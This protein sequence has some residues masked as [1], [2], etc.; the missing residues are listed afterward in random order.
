MKVVT[1][2]GARPQFIKCAPVSREL[3]KMATE[4]LVHTGQH[5][6][7]T[8]S[9]VFFRELE[10]PR[11]DYNLGVGSGPHGVQ[12]GETLKRIEEVLLEERP[13]HVVVYGD[14][15]S[16]LAGALAAAKLHIPVAHVEA[17][18]RS[19]NKR[20]PEEINR[21]MTDHISTLLFCPTETAVTNLTQEGMT[22][23]VHLVGD[24]MYD[25]LHSNL[26]LAE[27]MSTILEKL[28]LRSKGYLLTTVHRAENTDQPEN[29]S[30]IVNALIEIAES[31]QTVVFP[32]HPRTRKQLDALAGNG[33]AGLLMIDPVSYLDMVVLE[34]NA[35]AVLTDSGGV[36]KEVCW[37]GVPCVTLRDET[38]WV[39]TL[40]DGRNRLAGADTKRIY[41]AVCAALAAPEFAPP[42]VHPVGAANAIITCLANG[43]G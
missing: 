3:R 26:L 22:Q 42:V 34:K 7:D 5:Y 23:G 31:G 14:T 36:Q 38:E 19:F 43:R 21:V 39:E 17:G 13:D 25:A 1:V 28:G 16:T 15:N 11:P 29:L 12:T 10:I 32:V 30:N 2:I 41:A 6:D 35:K 4:V 18:L 33:C 9:E 20:M 27:R 24:V 40:A 8:M 37:L